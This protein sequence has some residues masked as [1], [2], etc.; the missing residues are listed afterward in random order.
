MDRKFVEGV[1]L[2][3][4]TLGFVVLIIWFLFFLVAGELINDIHE[5]V[6]SLDSLQEQTNDALR[7]KASYRSVM[8]VI[9]IANARK[10]KLIINM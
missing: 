9:D 10:I 7:G 1:L 2:R 4:F 3:C 6:L 8:K 5:L